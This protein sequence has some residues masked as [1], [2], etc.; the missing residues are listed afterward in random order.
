M[1]LALIGVALAAP[2]NVEVQTSTNVDVT[3]EWTAAFATHTWTTACPS[4]M[5]LS[6]DAFSVNFAPEHNGTN[7]VVSSKSSMGLVGGTVSRNGSPITRCLDA[8]LAEW[9]V[10]HPL[11]DQITQPD[12]FLLRVSWQHPNAVRQP[13]VREQI[14]LPEETVRR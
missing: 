2:G 8:E 9:L 14:M 10:E 4:V 6:D 3:K 12:S 13:V 1:I 7:W 11:D 5:T